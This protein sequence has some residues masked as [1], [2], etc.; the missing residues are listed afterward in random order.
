VRYPLT[1]YCCERRVLEPLTE[2]GPSTHDAS[3]TTWGRNPNSWWVP[4]PTN[5][6]T[7][8][9]TCCVGATSPPTSC[10]FIIRTGYYLDRSI[11]GPG[12]P[13]QQT[14]PLCCAGP[15]ATVC[16]TSRVVPSSPAPARHCLS[17]YDQ[18][19]T[20]TCTRMSISASIDF[21]GSVGFVRDRLA[22]AAVTDTSGGRAPA[23]W[24]SDGD[25]SGRSSRCCPLT[26]GAARGCCGRTRASAD[27]EV[28]H[29][30]GQ[31]PAGV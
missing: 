23:G 3:L 27:V 29:H 16:L 25:R 22:R 14:W 1:A 9:F 15:A 10:Y 12:L 31:H 28:R 21:L 7:T 18:K 8:H 11:T 13:G 5:R 4:A 17:P 19:T 20:H 6:S 26:A 24:P 30:W 2:T